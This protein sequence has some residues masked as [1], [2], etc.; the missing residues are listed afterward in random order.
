[1]THLAE[2]VENILDEFVT[3]GGGSI[4][5]LFGTIDPYVTDL[6]T[7]ITEACVEVV[8]EKVFYVSSGIATSI[9]YHNPDMVNQFDN[10]YEG[11]QAELSEAIRSLGKSEV[12]GERGIML[13]TAQK[14]TITEKYSSGDYVVEDF[15][16]EK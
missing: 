1:M 14:G 5:S 8:K 15:E 3:D 11:L 10:F 13:E 9:A 7:L 6:I 12:V 4:T 16:V 2:Q